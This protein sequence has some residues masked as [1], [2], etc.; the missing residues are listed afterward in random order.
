MTEKHIDLFLLRSK[1][2]ALQADYSLKLLD[3]KQNLLEALK[4]A[5]TDRE[6]EKIRNLYYECQEES[7]RMI[8][9]QEKILKKPI[10]SLSLVV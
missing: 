1:L 4:Q 10:G 8:K 6:K 7:M 3:F 9:E 5:P 2:V